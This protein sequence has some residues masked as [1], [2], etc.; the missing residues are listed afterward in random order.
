M[1]EHHGNTPPRARLQEYFL[2]GWPLQGRCA[3][4][5]SISLCLLTRDASHAG[6]HDFPIVMDCILTVWEAEPTHT[7]LAQSLLSAGY[8]V[9]ALS[10]VTEA[11][12]QGIYLQ[13]RQSTWGNQIQS[14]GGS[15]RGGSPGIKI[16]SAKCVYLGISRLIPKMRRLSSLYFEI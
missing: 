1:Q 5:A 15:R 8:F 4:N 2:R 13:I 11:G 12:G 3:L 14:C 7:C 6:C 9:T 10:Q 16:Y